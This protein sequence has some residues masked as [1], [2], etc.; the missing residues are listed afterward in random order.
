[1]DWFSID[2]WYT[3]KVVVDPSTDK[4]DIYINGALKKCSVAYENPVT[5]IDGFLVSSPSTGGG[6]MYIDDIKVY[7][8]STATPTPTP[9]SGTYLINDSFNSESTGSVPSGWTV[10]TAGGTATIAEIPGVSDKS[11]KVHDTNSQSVIATK[12]FTPQTGAVTA[13]YKFM[14]NSTADFFGPKLMSGSTQA[15]VVK[16][17][18][19]EIKFRD[20]SGLWVSLQPFSINIWYAVKLVADPVTDTIDIYIDGVQ[21]ASNATFENA[22]AS[23]D[24]FLVSS[25][26]TLTGIMYIDDIKVTN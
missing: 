7:N 10:D 19:G 2:T 13:E 5:S 22:V 25:P 26:S 8:D 6:V 14:V 20:S 16:T 11:M 23:I 18:D 17:K 12:T 1:M 21:K 9:I 24:G 3:V 15:T 4:M